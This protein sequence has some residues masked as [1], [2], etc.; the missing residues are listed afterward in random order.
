MFDVLPSTAC[1]DTV[2]LSSDLENA[3]TKARN[4]FRGL[5]DSPERNSILSALG[6]IGKASLKR[7]VRERIKLITGIVGGQFPE[8]DMVADYAVDCRNHYVHGSPSRINFTENFDQ[9]TFFI[10]TLEFVFA[11][12][13]LIESGW[14]ILSWSSQG[15]MHS[16]PFGRYRINYLN[17]LSRFKKLL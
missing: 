12:S 8:L 2:S 17:N 13:D 3:R 9:V 15:T 11:A 4:E 14:D 10:D 6:R 16:H 7:K 1:P 5:P